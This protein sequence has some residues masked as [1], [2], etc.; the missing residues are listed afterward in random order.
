MDS[1]T[2]FMS[3]D[4]FL[5]P[6]HRS[7]CVAYRS[8]VRFITGSSLPLAY[9]LLSR[10]ANVGSLF[11]AAIK[12][13]ATAFPC[14]SKVPR[15]HERGQVGSL[16]QAQRETKIL[17]SILVVFKCVRTSDN[18]E[19]LVMCELRERKCSHE[20]NGGRA[21][22]VVEDRLHLR[23]LDPLHAVPTSLG[24]AHHLRR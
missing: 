23:C 6:R 21:K 1:L 13:S 5:G 15:Q 22:N 14:I 17:N 19:A 3:L 24:P 2:T 8:I 20:G 7:M 9:L 10:T 18:Q 12:T 4:D 16:L 11:C